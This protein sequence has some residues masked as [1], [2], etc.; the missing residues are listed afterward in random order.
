MAEK[1]AKMEEKL[2]YVAESNQKWQKTDKNDRKT[3]K[4]LCFPNYPLPRFSFLPAKL[5]YLSCQASISVLPSTHFF[6]AKL[7]NF[8][9]YAHGC[10][11]ELVTILG[12]Q[13]KTTLRDASVVYNWKTGQ[14]QLASYLVTCQILQHRINFDPEKSKST[15]F[16][17]AAIN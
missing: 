17:I 9:S 4:M 15:L 8:S 11:Q 14:P 12:P 1:R 2:E 3:G 13:F 7:T 10:V 5:P 16:F 6:P